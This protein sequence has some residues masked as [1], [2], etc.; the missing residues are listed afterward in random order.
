MLIIRTTL[1]NFFKFFFTR[2]AAGY[3]VVR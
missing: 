3:V 2:K 1:H